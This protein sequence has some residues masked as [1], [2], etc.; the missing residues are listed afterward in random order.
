MNSGGIYG[1]SMGPIENMVF[2]WVHLQVFLV[3][4]PENRID[5][6]GILFFGQARF[7]FI[8]LVSK[9]REFDQ[10]WLGDS[11]TNTYS[12]YI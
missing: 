10:A 8:T 1:I 3:N 9:Q 2:L 4:L 5:S 6:A 11:V 12:I 7:G